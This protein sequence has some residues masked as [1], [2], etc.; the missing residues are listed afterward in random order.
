MVKRNQQSA[1]RR[2]EE[3]V[4]TEGLDSQQWVPHLYDTQEKFQLEPAPVENQPPNWGQTPIP[5]ETPAPA[6]V[7][8]N[9]VVDY[10]KD[11]Y[12]EANNE[13]A[14]RNF[15]QQLSEARNPPVKEYKTPPVP[16]AVQ[17]Q[18]E[19]EMA[20]GRKRVAEFQ[21][22]EVERQALSPKP[23]PHAATTT[24]VFRPADY[25]PDQKK[26]QGNTAVNRLR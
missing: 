8:D 17:T 2:A 20:A 26:N 19:L 21:Q 6:P 10:P 13:N 22:M 11:I 9:T 12:A 23:E 7:I 14:K 24:P 18:T 3:T 1:Y 25:V 5:V 16:K 4:S 15:M